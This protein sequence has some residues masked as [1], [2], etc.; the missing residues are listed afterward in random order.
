MAGLAGAG[1]RF[2]E[3]ISLRVTDVEACVRSVGCGSAARAAG[4]GYSRRSE[5]IEAVDAYL[6]GRRDRFGPLKSC[7]CAPTVGPI[8]F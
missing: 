2:G 6:A 8:D 1:V 7:S 5:V 4:G 3:A